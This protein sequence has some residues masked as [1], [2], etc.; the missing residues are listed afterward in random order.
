MVNVTWRGKTYVG[1][2]LDATRHDWAP[3]RLTEESD[4]RSRSLGFGGRAKRTGQTRSLSGSEDNSLS[5]LRNGES[6]RPAVSLFLQSRQ[7]FKFFADMTT[8][9]SADR[10]ADSLIH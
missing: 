2:L 9:R 1:T 7:S 8:E 4:E 6:V 10:F 3:P 5:K